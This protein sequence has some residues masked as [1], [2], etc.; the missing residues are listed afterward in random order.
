MCDIFYATQLTQF[1]MLNKPEKSGKN[2]M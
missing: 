1:F 2:T